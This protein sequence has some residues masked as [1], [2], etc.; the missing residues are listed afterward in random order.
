MNTSI[1][2]FNYISLLFSLVIILIS[3]GCDSGWNI[4]NPYKQVEWNNHQ[5]YKANLHTHTT[6]SDGQ[7]NPHTVV[8]KYHQLNYH[9][10]AITDH[11]EVT[12]PWTEFAEMD[13]SETAKERLEKGNL[14]AKNLDYE[15]RDP[16]KL[17]IIDIQGNELSSH[18]HMGSYFSDHNGTET[19]EASLSATSLKEGLLILNH[20]GRYTD[21]NPDKYNLNWYCDNFTQH[22]HLIGMEV[23]NQGDRYS[24]DRHLWDSILTR[25]MPEDPVWGFSND[26][27][28]GEDAL[29]R[30]WNLL[31]LPKLTEE[32]VRKGMKEGRFFYV[33]APEGHDGPEPPVIESVKV[34]RRK[35]TIELEAT[36]EESIEWISGGEVVQKGQIIQLDNLD[37]VEGYVRAEIHGPGET[38]VGTQAFGIQENQ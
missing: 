18:H 11:N 24:G 13:S 33:Y 35:G 22:D 15:N 12:W 10:L 29:G 28:H 31:V 27:M 36:G 14:Q 1:K 4:Q 2:R 3:T 16:E 19:E 34:N 8:D 9:I 21:Q 32:W 7:M 26:D 17:E 30:N 38:I 6:R 20:P 37:E 23:Y 5:Q 25:L